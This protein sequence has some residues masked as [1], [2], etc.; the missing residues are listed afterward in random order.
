MTR[1][2][3]FAFCF[4]LTSVLFAGVLQA[5]VISTLAGTGTGGYSGD[6][7]AATA[8]K[9]NRPYGVAI[10]A[11]GNIYIAD[12]DNNCVRKVNTSGV[13]NTIAGTGTAGYSGDGGAATAAKLNAPTGVAVDGSGNVYIADEKNDRVRVVNTSGTIK[14]FAGNGSAN[15]SGDGGA[16]T[17]AEIHSPWSVAADASGNIYITDQFN[18]RIRKVNTSG[19][20]STFAGT[21]TA[22]FSGDGG[23]ATAA[24]IYVPA[25]I[26]VDGS[27]NVLFVDE[28]NQRIRK[29]NTSGVINTI[30]GN[31]TPTYAGDGGAATAASLYNPYGVG[32]DAGGNVYIADLNNNRIRV[33]NT[34]G[35]ISTCAGKGTGGYTGDGGHATAAELYLPASVC[36]DL[37]GNV[38]IAD[39]IN[40][41]V[42]KVSITGLPSISGTSSICAGSTTTLTNATSGGTWSSSNTAVAT[43]GTGGV[44]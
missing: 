35:V 31:G 1:K 38:Y 39:Y 8:A 42:R 6:G 16:A 2:I 18:N 13:I 12:Q 33:V 11:G 24:K 14:T 4:I 30:A 41:C 28:N 26:T 36:T 21:G 29:I 43:V 37:G 34:S 44:V 3:F 27:G 32:T 23:A 40:N 9:I 5:Q 10:D 20:I 17:A 15:Y 22:G 25:G 7:G 19:V